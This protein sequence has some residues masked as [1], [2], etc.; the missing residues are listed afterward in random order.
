MRKHALRWRC[1][2]KSHRG[3]HFETDHDFR[4]HL[5]ENHKRNYS[6]GELA[7]L[8]DRSRQVIGPLF[9]SCPLCVD[10][11]VQLS[12]KLEEHIAGHLRWLALKSLP[13]VCLPDPGRWLLLCTCT[14]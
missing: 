11:S 13:L 2:V 14:W 12:E 1:P 10:E 5:V 7:L 9:A 6:E 4:S 8:I 3:E